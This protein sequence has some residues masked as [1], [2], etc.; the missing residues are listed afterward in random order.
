M[1]FIN[2]LSL[3][4]GQ[5]GH[6]TTQNKYF[7]VLLRSLT[8]KTIITADCG[9]FHTLFLDCIIFLKTVWITIIL[10]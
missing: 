3:Y 2:F 8:D 9:G 1:N 5:L 6:G 10:F 7:P 4:K